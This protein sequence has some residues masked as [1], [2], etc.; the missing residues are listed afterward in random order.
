MCK[1]E[2]GFLRKS[3]INPFNQSFKVRNISNSRDVL[4]QQS[5]LTKK[6]INVYH[7]PTMS[8]YIQ[9]LGF[10]V[11]G[12]IVMVDLRAKISRFSKDMLAYKSVLSG[13]KTEI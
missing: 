2:G 6:Y 12:R 3:A 10:L 4:C 9:R 7:H 11:L 1:F 5:I 13:F 8:I